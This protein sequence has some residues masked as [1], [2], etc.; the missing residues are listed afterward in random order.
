M[1][2]VDCQHDELLEGGSSDKV[3][4]AVF[5]AL[6]GAPMLHSDPDGG[7]GLGKVSVLS[8]SM[9]VLSTF[10]RQV[11]GYDRFQKRKG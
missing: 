11:L 7:A 6:D 3:A 1:R 5:H 10:R 2:I 4:A 8:I 9:S